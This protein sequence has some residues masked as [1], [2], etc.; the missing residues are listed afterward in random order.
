MTN[1]GVQRR[2]ALMAPVLTMAWALALAAA[3][4]ACLAP[5]GAAAQ[6][7]AGAIAPGDVLQMTVPGRPDLDR[8]LVVARDG[9]VEIPQV[10]EIRLAGLGLAEAGTVLK[11]RLRLIAPSLDTVEVARTEAASFRIYVLGE[12][13]QAG[14]HEFST[15]P[16]IWDVMRTAG[17]PLRSADL[18]KA[19]V[20]REEPGGPRTIAMD[21]AGLLD[22]EGF[23]QDELHNGDTLVVPALPA[24]VS[25]VAAARGVKVF[26]GVAVPSV[27]PVEEPTPLMDVLMLA[28]SPTA[29]AN[30]KKIWW[31]RAVDGTDRAQLVNLRLFLEKGDPAG[32]PEILPGDTVNVTLSKPGRIQTTFGFLLGTAATIAAIMVAANQN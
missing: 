5:T 2:T 14:M 22:G 4:A 15:P 18:R 7:P 31:V 13:G 28:G 24:G 17:G 12:V 3:L 32:N 29:D 8:T 20:I 10:G 6:E 25:G 30:L 23:P 11:Q 16:S 26:G 1:P 19:R 9:T 27:V 21:L